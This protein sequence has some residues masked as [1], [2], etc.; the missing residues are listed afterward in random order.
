MPRLR[1]HY[2]TLHV[3]RDAPIDVIRSAYRT[4]ARK[5]HPD[6][7]GDAPGSS[8]AMQA[9]NAAYEVLSNPLTRAEH[10]RWIEAH[11]AVDPPEAPA[12]DVEADISEGPDIFDDR[13]PDQ[14]EPIG[15]ARA[16]LSALLALCY[17]VITVSFLLIPG[18]RVIGILLLIAGWL[19]YRSHHS[20]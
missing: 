3:S 6:R 13:S 11:I 16:V 8:A 2:D 18:A 17:I 12:F 5:Y 14:A 7:R 4:L 10:D 15:V 9:L 1:T 20:R 19:Y